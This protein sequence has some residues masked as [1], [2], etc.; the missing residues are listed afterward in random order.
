[1]PCIHKLTDRQFVRCDIVAIQQHDPAIA[2][3]IEIDCKA[4]AAAQVSDPVRRRIDAGQPGGAVLFD[5]SIERLA[6]RRPPG[7]VETAVDARRYRACRSRDP[8]TSCQG[9]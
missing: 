4:I 3:D 5:Q 6:V 7:L 2:R 9:A 1:V 8:T